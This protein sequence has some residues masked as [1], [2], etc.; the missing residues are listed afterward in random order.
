MIKLHSAKNIS[1]NAYPVITPLHW[2]FS[3][4]QYCPIVLVAMFAAST[5][6]LCL[7]P[8]RTEREFLKSKR[9][10]QLWSRGILETPVECVAV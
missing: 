2:A 1:A 3:R 8:V 4:H 5:A 9:A 7:H 10:E 6:F